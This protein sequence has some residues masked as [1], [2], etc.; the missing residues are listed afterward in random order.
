MRILLSALLLAGLA[1]AQEDTKKENKKEDL[2]VEAIMRLADQIHDADPKKAAAAKEALREFG[3]ATLRAVVADVKRQIRELEKELGQTLFN[4]SSNFGGMFVLDGV[5]GESGTT[6]VH[7]TYTDDSGKAHRYSLK[8][9][10]KGRYELKSTTTDENG[11]EKEVKAEGTMAELQI[12]YSFLKGTRPLGVPRLG[13]REFGVRDLQGSA[14]EFF[15]QFGLSRP[16]ARSL[17]KLGATVKKPS[18]ELAYHLALPAGA[19]LVID[20][21]RKNSRAEKAGL[22][23]HDVILKVNGVFLDD[24]RDLERLLRKR[25][26]G[27]ITLDVIRRAQTVQV[28]LPEK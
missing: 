11:Q 15:P 7:G 5:V 2:D 17:R 21:V 6:Y 14:L 26:P 1:F 23:R 8:G 16:T 3:T 13:V 25:A 10:G 27:K 24:P 9:L 18:E 12:K 22:R 19:G 4:F 28:D 20:K